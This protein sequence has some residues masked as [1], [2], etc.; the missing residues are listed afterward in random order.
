MTPDELEA[1]LELAFEHCD[2]AEVPLTVEQKQLLRRSLGVGDA[3]G[4]ARNPLGQLAPAERQAFLEFVHHCQQQ[5]QAWKRV[6][7]N[8]WLQGRESGPVQFLRDRYGLQWLEH[9]TPRHLAEYEDWLE[10]GSI[11]LQ[12]GD[13][14]E[15]S[16]GLWEWVQDSGPCRREWFPCTVIGLHNTDREEPPPAEPPAIAPIENSPKPHTSCVVRFDS[17]AE[18]EIQ[19]IYEWNRPN[20]R[21]PEP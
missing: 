8:D 19:G 13:R 7:F 3:S 10:S 6:L 12:I 15:V 16:N 9:I 18:Y 1:A 14:I 17:G 11:Q 5:S 21:W 2:R 4:R 20:W